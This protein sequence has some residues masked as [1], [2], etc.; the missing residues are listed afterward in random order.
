MSGRERDQIRQEGKD[1]GP[2]FLWLFRYY[3]DINDNIHPDLRQFSLGAVT[4]IRYGRY[5][6]NGF[7][8]RSTR[9]EDAHSLAATTNSRAV[10]RAIDDE[11]KVTNYYG[12][13]NDILEYKFFGDKQLK[14]VFFNCDWLTPNTTRENQYGMVKSNTTIDYKATTL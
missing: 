13:I 3:V 11:G 7:R 14:V 9:F 6:V 2:N 8:F 5:D 12:V 10:T 1:G 4:A